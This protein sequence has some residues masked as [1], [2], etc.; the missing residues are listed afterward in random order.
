M[1]ISFRVF[2]PVWLASMTLFCAQS[3]AADLLE[4]NRD[5]KPILVETCF[6]CHGS[7]SAARQADL[8][9]DQREGA[10][11]FGAIVPGNPDES[12]VI[13]RIFADDESIL[14]PPPK[15]HKVL[16]ADQKEKLR[17]WIAQGAEYQ[18][19]W[20]FSAPIKPEV[21]E[22]SRSEWVKNPIDAFV[23]AKLDE[24]GLTPAEPADRRTI[25][26]RVS[27]D[28]TGL[29]PNP[30]MVDE[31]VNDAGEN[32]Y[33]AYVDRL[34]ATPQWGEHRARYWM[35]Y[36]RYGD[37]HGIHFDNYREMYSYRDWVIDAFNRNEPFDTFTIE[38]LAGD[39][40]PDSTLEQQIASGF[41]R[42]NI[43]TN[44]GGIIDEE[45]AVFYTRDRTE[46]F[47]QVWLGLTTGCAVCHD[48]KFDPLS[49]KEFYELSAFF[50]NTTQAVKDGNRKDTPPVIVVPEEQD[51]ERYETISVE[52]ARVGGRM[53]TIENER[54][55]EF[56]SLVKSGRLAEKLGEPPTDQ[57]V[58]HAPLND[59]ELLDRD[60][61]IK[62]VYAKPEEAVVRAFAQGYVSERAWTSVGS[63]PLP[64]FPGVGDFKTDEPFSYGAWVKTTG[65]LTGSVF[66]RMAAQSP[67]QGWDL[68]LDGNKVAC[69]I[70]S[71]WQEDALKVTTKTAIKPNNWE[72]LFVTY[73]GS[74]KASGIKIYINGELQE[75][76]INSDRLSTSTRSTSPFLIGQRAQG[77]LLKNIAI[78]DVR[79]YQ[80]T[81]EETT[82]KQVAFTSRLEYTSRQENEKLSKAELEGYKRFWLETVDEEYRD[83]VNN[84]IQLTIEN[85]TIESR[86]TIAHVMHEKES[87]AMAFVLSRGEYDKHLD[88]VKPQTPEI[89]PAFGAD[90]PRNR[91]GLAQWVMDESHPLTDRVTVNRFW[92]EV[93]GQGIV[94]TSGDF[95]ITGQPPTHPELLDWLAI[96]FRRSGRD[97]KQL[98]KLMVMSNTYRQASVTTAEKL[99]KDESNHFFSR[100]PRF[101]MDAEMVRDYTLAASGI[102]TRTIGGPSVKPYQ[103]EGVWESITMP[104]SD[105]FEYKQDHGEALYRRSMYTFWKRSAPPASMEIFNAPSRESCVVRRERTNTPLQALVTLNDIQSIEAARYLAERAIEAGRDDDLAVLDFIARRLL[106]RSLNEQEQRVVIS[107]VESIRQMYAQSPQEAE[108]L[109]AQGEYKSSESLDDVEL[110]SWTLI[111]NELMNL[112][113]VLCK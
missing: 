80:G 83:L 57:L 71:N 95:G 91:L 29:P 49:Q 41:N 8:R 55:Q 15:S 26:R 113:E 43:T 13:E 22:V 90:R 5:I 74:M 45:Y 40:L 52:L 81:L 73:D 85:N 58:F 70:I 110:A 94:V 64:A 98:F 108:Q 67:N 25:A 89:L 6:Q 39:L 54:E 24:M 101:R 109:I 28:I 51:R 20:S 14:M 3:A 33:E 68:Y 75:V 27:L 50:N 31:F 59:R 46:T 107:S 61:Q 99:E 19:H 111:V 9:L 2:V 112:D 12:S 106:A 53:D 77:D 42:C 18:P 96:E 78:A 11:E 48:H 7:D 102:M 87:P 4:Y 86:G 60:G 92:Q 62:T 17:A 104:N 65:R 34:L 76:A 36:S 63:D 88:E 69:H 103:P 35:D 100:G 10:V 79:V 16:T 38:Q 23:L 105:T 56:K 1:P 32:A 97:V 82:V 21:P 84:E 93:F 66:S 72:H 37:T 44:E 30:E 47:G